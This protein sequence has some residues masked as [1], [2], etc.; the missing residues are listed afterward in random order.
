M[1]QVS[2]PYR[3]FLLNAYPLFGKI[4]EFCRIATLQESTSSSAFGGRSDKSLLI[5]CMPL[6]EVWGVR[7]REMGGC[8]YGCVGQLGRLL[9][10]SLPGTVLCAHC[11]DSQQS[12]N[13]DPV[14]A[15][16]KSK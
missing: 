10:Y 4:A 12:H 8:G 14:Y 1:K 6:V 2:N 7:G 16:T 13:N 9:G 11:I 5:I 15:A 3:F